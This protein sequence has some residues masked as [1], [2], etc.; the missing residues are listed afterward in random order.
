LAVYVIQKLWTSLYQMT[1]RNTN[2]V[3]ASRYEEQAKL[4]IRVLKHPVDL[5]VSEGVDLN[6]ILD[7]SANQAD[8]HGLT[9]G[10]EGSTVIGNVPQLESADEVSVQE[11]NDPEEVEMNATELRTRS[12]RRPK[13]PVRLIEELLHGIEVIE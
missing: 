1:P 12:G 6:Q 10:P 7:F 5:A 2:L 4:H 13:K 11:M 3:A 9:R 8:D